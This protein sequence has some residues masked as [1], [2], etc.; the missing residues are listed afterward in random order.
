VRVWGVVE[1]SGKND[2]R[3]TAGDRKHRKGEKRYGRWMMSRTVVYT[4]ITRRRTHKVVG[5]SLFV[6]KS[7]KRYGGQGV[8]D[9]L[10]GRFA[11]YKERQ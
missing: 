9:R 8:S 11:R 2:D 5:S 10:L 6:F 4:L 1:A 7:G 3:R